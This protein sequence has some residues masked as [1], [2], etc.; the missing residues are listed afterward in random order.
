MATAESLSSSGRSGGHG[1]AIDAL[2]LDLASRD[3][4]LRQRARRSLVV[5]GD[6]AVPALTQTL[7]SSDTRLRWEAAKTLIDIPDPRSALALVARLEDE[8]PGIRWVAAEALVSL[9][10]DA[11]APLLQRLIDRSESLWVRE[12]AHHVLHELAFGAQEEVLSPVLAAL[13]GPAPD[14]VV[15]VVAARALRGRKTAGE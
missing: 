4:S 12:G 7:E 5:I 6:E 1:P 13:E 2:L 14:E 10:A 3:G 8:D 11:L 9:G 15:P